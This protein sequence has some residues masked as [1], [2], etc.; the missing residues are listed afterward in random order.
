MRAKYRAL[1][2]DESDNLV[3][4][5]QRKLPFS[6]EF[7][8]LICVQDYI[9]AI[10]NMVVRGAGV[11]GNVAGFG[12]CAALKESG[13]CADKFETLCH[14][15]VSSRPTAINLLYAI[16]MVKE[17]VYQSSFDHE[18]ALKKAIDLCDDDAKQSLK[19]ANIGADAIK[20]LMERESID[21]VTVLTHCNA[22]YLAIV[23]NGSALAPIYE[24][25]RRGVKVKVFV[26]ETR[27]RNQGASLTAWELGKEG[28]EHTII[29]D[30]TGGYLMQQNMIDLCIVGADRV[31]LNGDVVNK[32]GTYLKALSAKESKIP[33]F[34]AL[35]TSTFDFK[36][37]SA[38]S[39]PIEIRDEDELRY[40]RGVDEC[41]KEIKVKI[42]PDGSSVL[43][44]S[45]DITPSALVTSLI[46]ERGL[47][48]ADTES[49]ERLFK[50]LI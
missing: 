47:C 28:I 35:P 16:D 34:V 25:H 24:L 48:G 17:V 2:L 32:I 49:I 20:M 10:A 1:W 4:L 15:L 30:N 5:D 37:Q 36:S 50:D 3:V 39:T 41:G 29:C 33:F 46:T 43:N 6:E 8:T 12:V 21:E 45:F 18:S 38:L 40:V 19:I 14:A 27:P 7:I 23:D 31:S 9:D 26:D 11:I 13:F 44:Y 22:G 42:Y